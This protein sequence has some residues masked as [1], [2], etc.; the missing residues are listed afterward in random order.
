MFM[1]AGRARGVG[2]GRNKRSAVPES[3]ASFRY[4]P[5]LRKLVPAYGF[6]EVPCPN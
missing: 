2:V 5:E 3:A 6:V 1:E 4:M